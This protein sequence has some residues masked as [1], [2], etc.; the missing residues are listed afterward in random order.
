M[1]RIAHADGETLGVAELWH[2]WKSTS[3]QW[4]N[5]FTILTI[6]VD[7]HP[8]FKPLLDKLKADLQAVL[9]APDL[10]DKLTGV[11][12]QAAWIDGDILVKS[13]QTESAVT[14]ALVKEL[15]LKP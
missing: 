12:I 2:P 15:G 11:G 5:N 14:A 1:T 10:N 4:F 3:G 8:I 6:N 9:S 7:I 13:F